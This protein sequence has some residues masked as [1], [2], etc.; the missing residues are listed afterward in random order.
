MT[1]LLLILVCSVFDILFICRLDRQHAVDLQN[2]AAQDT[3]PKPSVVP[4]NQ[5]T[6]NKA[7]RQQGNSKH[8]TPVNI[9]LTIHNN[10]LQ[11]PMVSFY[12]TYFRRF[13]PRFLLYPVLKG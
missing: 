11:D 6:G 4:T 3:N 12:S 13:E 10:L 1:I 2:V 5:S 9:N 7:Q 8:E